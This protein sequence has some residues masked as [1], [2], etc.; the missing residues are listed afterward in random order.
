[1]TTSRVLTAGVYS[2]RRLLTM[3]TGSAFALV[4]RQP[5]REKRS[6]RTPTIEIAETVGG[7]VTSYGSAGPGATAFTPPG[8]AAGDA[9]EE[10][11]DGA[12]LAATRRR[13]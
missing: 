1:M 5:V 8:P 6:T 2:M 3:A 4:R 7:I 12:E 13:G 9:I 10:I 11:L